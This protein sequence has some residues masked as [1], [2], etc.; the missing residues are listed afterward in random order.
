MKTIGAGNFCEK[1]FTN[2]IKDHKVFSI[3]YCHHSTHKDSELGFYHILNY[4][5]GDIPFWDKSNI[6]KYESIKN[7]YKIPNVIHYTFSSTILPLEI[8]KVIEN[9]KKK[10]VNCHFV[11]Y[12]DKND[13][14]FL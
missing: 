2:I 9:N 4:D 6:E 1:E 13:G 10:C 7:G 8:Y 5:I 12:N 11:F 3:P 14:V